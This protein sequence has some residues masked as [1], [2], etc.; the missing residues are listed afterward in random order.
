MV[1]YKKIITILVFVLLV[2]IGYFFNNSGYIS[3][4]DILTLLDA[5]P[6]MAPLIFIALQV[7][8]TLLLLPTLPMNLGAG[9]LW[10]P[11]MGGFYTLIG[12]S[13]AAAIAFH[14]SRYSLFEY[15]RRHSKY[16][17]LTW[18]MSNEKEKGW[19]VVAFTRINPIFPTA[20]MNYLYGLT[21]IEFKIY[22]I[23]TI[24][25]IAPMTFLFAYIGDTIGSVLL[26]GDYY[27]L[28]KN[29]FI[30]STLFTLLIVV[31]ILITKALKIKIDNSNEQ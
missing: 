15:F 26:S 19:K 14:I 29:I 1:E 28:I 3:F 8:L 6:L 12:S 10:G 20:I 17:I 16:K 7:I 23:F 13:I 30:G 2:V 21:L 31:K 22:I 5:N 11:L 24:V 9:L 4:E 25:F 27:N 18:L